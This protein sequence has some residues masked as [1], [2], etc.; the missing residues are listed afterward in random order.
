MSRPLPDLLV[1]GGG[2]V[3]SAAAW[4]AAGRGARVHVLE[5]FGRGHR[6][7]SHHGGAR[8]TRHAYFEHPD[9][10]PLLL[11][12]TRL[13]DRLSAETGRSLR[14][15]CGVLIAGDPD[16]E[17]VRLSA[18]SAQRWDIPVSWL[19]GAELAEQ[20]PLLDLEGKVGLF[21]P[22][23][24]YL[25][26]EAMVRAHLDAAQALG[27]TVE[28]GVHATAI[29]EQADR[30]VV[31]TDA[32]PRAARALVV[33]SGAYTPA[34]VPGWAPLLTVTRELQGWATLGDAGQ[35]L[36]CW[37]LD[38][39][40]APAL[41]GLPADPLA[42]RNAPWAG[43]GKIALHGGGQAVDPEAPWPAASEAEWD[44]LRAAT[45][46]ALRSPA[47][48]L[49]AVWPCRYTTTPDSHFLLGALPGHARA[50]GAA[51]LS[52]HGF[53]LAPALGAALADLALDNQT[54]L[55]VGFLDP[56]RLR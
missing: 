31:H 17:L 52:G 32:G 38:Q 51:G 34:L 5:R 21:E 44:R 27:A 9:Y 28:V 12:A 50:W 39:G 16:S 54:D 15:A 41:Y 4:L 42:P 10:V 47:P 49:R 1:L 3:G 7:G 37:L 46:A 35:G 22:G 23:G 2:A 48:A 30:V 40:A 29:E 11:E 26:C 55:P 24:G 8:V 18:E 6:S 19:R 56:E 36:P 43:R 33:A 13:S 14:E 45:R 20:M 53:K 25:R